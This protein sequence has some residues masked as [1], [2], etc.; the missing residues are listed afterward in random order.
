[1]VDGAKLD[2]DCFLEKLNSNYCR[3]YKNDV[4][5]PSICPTRDWAGNE[6]EPQHSVAKQNY[7]DH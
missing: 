3:M 5:E 2:K 4:Q 7:S 6:C 1:M